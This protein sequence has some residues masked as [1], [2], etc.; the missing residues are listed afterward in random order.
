MDYSGHRP[1]RSG[2]ASIA[3]DDSPRNAATF[4]ARLSLVTSNRLVLGQTDDAAPAD[5]QRAFESLVTSYQIAVEQTRPDRTSSLRQVVRWAGAGA[6]VS[7]ASAT[8]FAPWQCISPVALQRAG[9]RPHLPRAQWVA[10]YLLTSG[11]D[12]AVGQHCIDTMLM[13]PHPDACLA[14]D[15]CDAALPRVA[16]LEA[17]IGTARAQGRSRLAII[18]HARCRGAMARRL[19]AANRSLTSGDIELEVV[20]IEQALGR[21]VS[22]AHGWDAIIALPELRSIVFA[23]LAQTSG[24]A[25]PWPMAWYDRGDARLVCAEALRDNAAPLP[26]DATLLIQCLAL[27]ACQAGLRYEASALY[28]GWARLRDNGVV[29]P[30]R[31]SSAPYVKQVSDAEFVELVCARMTGGSRRLPGWKTV[32]HNH[33]ND[34]VRSPVS[35]TIVPQR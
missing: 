26:L 16:A 29:T 34:A 24:V 14:E 17:M 19:L 9:G 7:T 2:G 4:G 28:E 33:G 31:G 5:W 1:D 22:V 25:A 30:G 13:S 3:S 32:D 27:A 15:D 10:S 35:L 11:S 18:V 6:G 12:Y 8:V 23:V 20:S 21:L